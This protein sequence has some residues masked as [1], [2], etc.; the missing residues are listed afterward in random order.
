MT[1]EPVHSSVPFIARQAR[2]LMQHV[3]SLRRWRGVSGGEGETR[4]AGWWPKSGG[5]G[6]AGVWAHFFT[7]EAGSVA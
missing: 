3:R 1:L 2:Y 7:E 6:S 4:A 5:L